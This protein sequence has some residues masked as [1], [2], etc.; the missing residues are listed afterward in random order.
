MT[1][2]SNQSQRPL[3]SHSIVSG[4]IV[5]LITIVVVSL[6]TAAWDRTTDGSL[7]KML[8]G[9]AIENLQCKAYPTE[10]HH[11]PKQCTAETFKLVEW[12]SGDCNAD[13]A[14]VTICCNR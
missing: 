12:C 9:A 2:K 4:V 13:D 11:P 5:G 10:E 3:M 7:I 6:M 8:G 1:D 14:R